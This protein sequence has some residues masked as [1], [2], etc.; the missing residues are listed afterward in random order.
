[1]NNPLRFLT[2]LLSKNK[3][4]I[5]L[6]EM[7]S[8][9]AMP[10][11]VHPRMGENIIRH[12]LEMGASGSK[13]DMLATAAESD[14]AS[15]RVAIHQG[16][17][18]LDVSGALV[19]RQTEGICGVSPASY[20]AMKADIDMLMND[21][22][23][24]T[25]IGRFDTPGG[26][27]AQNLDLADFIYAQRGKGKRLVAMVDDMAY[28]A[29]YS[30]ASAFDEIWVTRTGGVG[31]I[32]VVSYHE[33]RSEADK[34]AGL[35][36]DYIYAGDKKVWGNPH[37]ALGDE[38]R[39]EKQEEITDMYNMFVATVARNL[40]MDVQAVID[41]QAGTFTGAKAIEAGF[42]HKLGT[43][44]ELL[45]SIFTQRLALGSVADTIPPN[46]QMEQ[47]VNNVDLAQ[48]ELS[49]ATAKLEEAKSK[50]VLAQEEAL[51][52]TDEAESVEESNM[53]AE[54]LAEEQAKEAETLAKAE[55]L[56]YESSIKAMCS[57]AGVE[58]SANDFI[59]SKMEV[60]EVRKL[61]LELTA[62]PAA[63]IQ[64]STGAQLETTQ[65][66]IKSGWKSAFSKVNR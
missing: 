25:V 8:A 6:N 45:Q 37:E 61:L 24:D 19:A 41:T 23:I 18:V 49:S 58:D 55:Q 54:A 38:A 3:G 32:G 50:L 48:S 47:T 4:N 15:G 28:S 53:Q 7:H 44:D 16:V 17:A 43:F 46:A 39:A 30:M 27:A 66:S 2:K 26:M 12:Y 60:G 65:A 10:M 9:M 1:M 11:F 13:I 21:S 20:E 36:V 35:K 14:Y 31:S 56:Q 63:N 22:T 59:A 51:K 64:N 52:V 34:M 5:V 33:D 62:S 42:A 29:G 40:G 57:A